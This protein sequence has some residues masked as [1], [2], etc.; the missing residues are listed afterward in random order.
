MLNFEDH[1]GGGEKESRRI[2]VK[3]NRSRGAEE[4]RSD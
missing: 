3:E 2:G 4:K 1:G